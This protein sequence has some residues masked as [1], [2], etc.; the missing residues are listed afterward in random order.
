MEARVDPVAVIVPTDRLRSYTES[1]RGSHEITAVSA[2]K[3]NGSVVLT[4]MRDNRYI[5]L[6]LCITPEAM[7]ELAVKWLE[8]R[9]W[10]TFANPNFRRRKNGGR[11]ML[12][13]SVRKLL[14]NV[15]GSYPHFVELT[16]AAGGIPIYV[17]EVHRKGEY[18]NEKPVTVRIMRPAI[19]EVRVS[20]QDAARLIHDELGFPLDTF[21]WA[22]SSTG[23]GELKHNE[24]TEHKVIREA[25]SLLKSLES[26]LQMGCALPLAPQDA[27]LW[28]SYIEFDDVVGARATVKNGAERVELVIT[29]FVNG[30]CVHRATSDSLTYTFDLATNGKHYC[31]EIGAQE[32]EM[33]G[34][35]ARATAKP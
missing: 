27:A 16:V 7:D 33:T 1:G 30:E 32:R 20:I 35:A 26:L 21:T 17:I 19:R 5:G 29:W 31:L 28:S 23:W 11:V 34:A 22:V 15:S 9:G 12:V 2:L 13:K 14:M 24:P 4:G 8:S 25:A 10:K 3:M 18:P 6:D